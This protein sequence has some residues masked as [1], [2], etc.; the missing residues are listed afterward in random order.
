MYNLRIEHDG[1]NF[2]DVPCSLK[3]QLVFKETRIQ[4]PP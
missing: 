4:A 1:K 3:I 2:Q